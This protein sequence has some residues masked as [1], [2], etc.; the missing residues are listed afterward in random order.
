MWDITENNAFVTGLKGTFNKKKKKKE[1]NFQVC[2]SKEY[3]LPLQYSELE[4]SCCKKVSQI[5]DLMI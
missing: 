4:D 2:F 5:F 3:I 1:M